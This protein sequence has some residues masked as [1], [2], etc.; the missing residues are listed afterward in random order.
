MTVPFSFSPKSVFS[1]HVFVFN[2]MVYLFLYYYTICDE[3]YNQEF[4]QEKMKNVL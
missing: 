3:S 1:S 4:V 2:K